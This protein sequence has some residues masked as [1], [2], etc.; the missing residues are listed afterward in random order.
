LHSDVTMK[1]RIPLGGAGE[2]V[3]GTELD[4]FELNS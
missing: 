2:T 4:R 3:G 1:V